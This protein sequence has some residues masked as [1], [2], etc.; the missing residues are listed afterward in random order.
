MELAFV[1]IDQGRLTEAE[2]LLQ[3][4]KLV[5]DYWLKCSYLV[6]LKDFEVLFLVD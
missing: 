4:T 6:T 1:Y 2:E 3:S 5:Y